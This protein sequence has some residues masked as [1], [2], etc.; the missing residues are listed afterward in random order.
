VNGCFVGMG[1]ASLWLAGRFVDCWV[2]HS[3]RP[4]RETAADLVQPRWRSPLAEA[5]TLI[6]PY[7]WRMWMFLLSTVRVTRDI[8]EWRPL[9]Q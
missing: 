1:V 8:T 4:L 5:A 9:W 2:R 7:G 6:N 3:V